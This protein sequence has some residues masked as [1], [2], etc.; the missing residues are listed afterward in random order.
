MHVNGSKVGDDWIYGAIIVAC[1]CK[2]NVKASLD[3][4]PI[5]LTTS[6]GTPLSKYSN[7]PPILMP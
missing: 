2:Y 6:K 3:H 4:L 7:V 5:D 1:L